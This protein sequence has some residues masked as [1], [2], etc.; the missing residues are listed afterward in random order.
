MSDGDDDGMVTDEPEA[1]FSL[2]RFRRLPM[3][4]QRD[5]FTQIAEWL[6][7]VYNHVD[8]RRRVNTLVDEW[9]ADIDRGETPDTMHLV[10]IKGSHETTFRFS[11]DFSLARRVN[12]G[13]ST[14]LPMKDMVLLGDSMARKYGDDEDITEISFV[15]R[16]APG[17]EWTPEEMR[18]VCNRWVRALDKKLAWP[19]AVEFALRKRRA[20][21]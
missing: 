8:I 3:K 16:A 13:F 4:K 20:T 17:M 1:V 2:C 14:D 6:M 21:S 12:R 19:G 10:K 9:H 7:H 15:F 11:T 18:T 5:A